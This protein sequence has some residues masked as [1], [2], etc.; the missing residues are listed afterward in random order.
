[1]YDLAWEKIYGLMTVKNLTEMLCMQM[2]VC[3]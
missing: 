2:Y 1:M 3:L